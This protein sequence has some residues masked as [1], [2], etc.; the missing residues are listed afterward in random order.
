MYPEATHRAVPPESRGAHLDA[1]E[2]RL[3]IKRII[4]NVT[5][6][7]AETIGDEANFR[8]DLDLDSLSLLEIAVDVD[9]E[10]QLNVP[11]ERLQRIGSLTDAVALVEQTL[12]AR[13]APP[14][15]V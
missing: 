3:R 13:A 1:A 2:I 6:I 8:E 10:F 14:E 5:N 7:P 9:Y 15:V 4:T 11:E 12:A